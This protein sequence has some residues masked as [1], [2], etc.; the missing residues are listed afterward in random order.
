MKEVLLRSLGA[1]ILLLLYEILGYPAIDGT[2]TIFY[3]KS[4]S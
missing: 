2:T 3:E 1:Q 4:M